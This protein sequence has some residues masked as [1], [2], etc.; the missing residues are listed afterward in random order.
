MPCS[1]PADEAD[2][3]LPGLHRRHL[4]GSLLRRGPSTLFTACS[5]RTPGERD[6]ELRPTRCH[7]SHRGLPWQD[8]RGRADELVLYRVRALPSCVWHGVRSRG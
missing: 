3:P 8:A 7:A 4:L 6:V 1:A 2:D 5:S